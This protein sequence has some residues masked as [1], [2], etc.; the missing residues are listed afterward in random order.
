MAKR[1]AAGYHAL[2]SSHSHGT[3]RDPLQDI[4]TVWLEGG[5][6][7]LGTVDGDRYNFWRDSRTMQAGGYARK[8]GWMIIPEEQESFTAAYQVFLELFC[9]FVNF[10]VF[11]RL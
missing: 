5:I 7:N 10:L 4:A 2:G 11:V 8:D 1:L 6:P 9:K 3:T